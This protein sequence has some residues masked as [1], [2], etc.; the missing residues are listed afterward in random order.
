M[1]CGI[2][3]KLSLLP[4]ARTRFSSASTFSIAKM[5]PTREPIRSAVSSSPTLGDIKTFVM[6]E[7]RSFDNVSV[8]SL[9]TEFAS[10]F[11]N[12]RL[13]SMSWSI[14]SIECAEIPSSPNPGMSADDVLSICISST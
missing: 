2:I 14:S 11:F 6:L 5:A 9:S 12:Q 1:L 7:N 4:S 10:V 8:V 13:L 3:A